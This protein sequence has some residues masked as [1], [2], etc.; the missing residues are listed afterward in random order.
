MLLPYTQFVTFRNSGRNVTMTEHVETSQPVG[1]RNQVWIIF[2]ALI[3]KFLPNKNEHLALL[4]TP[5]CL[6]MFTNNPT[7]PS[8]A[9]RFI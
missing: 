7:T 4:A 3:Q 1:V 5:L 6:K 2:T 8:Y 9:N